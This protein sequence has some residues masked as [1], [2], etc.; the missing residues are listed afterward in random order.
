M[1][2]EKLFNTSA[3]VWFQVCPQCRQLWFIGMARRND[4]YSCKDCGQEFN[5]SEAHLPLPAAKRGPRPRPTV[6]AA[7]LEVEEVLRAA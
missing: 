2:N 6:S 1:L 4:R 3:N 5:I 7:C